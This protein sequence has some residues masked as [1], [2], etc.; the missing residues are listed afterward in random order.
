MTF[1]VSKTPFKSKT[2]SFQNQPNLP[3]TRG[4]VQELGEVLVF[5]ASR[6]GPHREKLVTWQSSYD[7]CKGIDA[8]SSTATGLPRFAR[9][10][11]ARA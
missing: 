11:D 3:G 7:A 5:S 8:G 2:R 6:A 10:D 4:A 9:N 1:K